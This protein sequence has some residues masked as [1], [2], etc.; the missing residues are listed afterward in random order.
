M[1]QFGAFLLAGGLAA[2]ANIRSRILFSL[3]LPYGLAIFCGYAVGVT[4]A[5]A[6]NRA[7]VFDAP[8]GAVDRQYRRFVLVNLLAFAQVWAVSMLLARLVFPAT[9][10]AWHAETV[11][12]VIGVLSPVATSFWLHKTYSFAPARSA[13]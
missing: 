2:L 3:V 10:F 1:R 13:G 8:Q 11:A 4:L 5:F 7:F 6:L 9:G 12:H